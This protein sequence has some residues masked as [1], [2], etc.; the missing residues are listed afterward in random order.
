MSNCTHDNRTVDCV[1]KDCGYDFIVDPVKD[2]AAQAE[3][4]RIIKLLEEH[5]EQK[6]ADN[7]QRNDD[8]VHEDVCKLCEKFNGLGVAIALIKGENK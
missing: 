8:L 7:F 1:C 2:R 6:F 3:R 5:S 4:E